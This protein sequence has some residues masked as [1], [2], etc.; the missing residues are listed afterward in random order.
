MIVGVD[1]AVLQIVINCLERDSLERPVRAEILGDLQTSMKDVV[2]ESELTKWMAI[3]HDPT[4]DVGNRLQALSNA[5]SRYV[6]Q[7]TFKDDYR[8]NSAIE[9]H[10]TVLQML[11]KVVYHVR[12]LPAVSETERT[13]V[14]KLADEAQEFAKNAR[15]RQLEKQKIEGYLIPDYHE[16]MNGA[17]LVYKKY[18]TELESAIALAEVGHS[19]IVPL[20][21]LGPILDTTKLW[22]DHPEAGSYAIMVSNARIPEGY[23]VAG[24]SYYSSAVERAREFSILLGVDFEDQVK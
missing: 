21:R 18:C 20:T 7:P 14:Y 1:S 6:E 3:I 9:N 23:Q 12:P 11:E 2:Q 10:P 16:P 22:I 8:F 17:N 19:S 5:L 24:S 13:A 4:I 15:K